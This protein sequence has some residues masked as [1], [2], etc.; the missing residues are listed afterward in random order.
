MRTEEAA[1]VLE[2]GSK[3]R[4]EGSSPG[5]N[6]QTTVSTAPEVMEKPEQRRFTAEYKFRILGRCL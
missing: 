3:E 1:G 4:P 2:A 5:S 6:L